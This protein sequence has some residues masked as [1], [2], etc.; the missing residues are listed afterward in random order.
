M[1]ELRPNHFHAGLDI[2]TEGRTGLPVYAAEFGFI[3][4]I[5]IQEG[6]YGNALYVYHPS[7]KQTT[8]YAHLKKFSPKI[9]QYVR[10]KQYEK[11]TFTIELFPQKTDFP[12]TRG[13]IIAYSGNTGG[14]GGPHLHFEIR[15]KDQHL[16]NPLN[17][18]FK[19]VKDDIPPNIYEVL[20]STRTK[21]SRVNNEFGKTP[22]KPRKI[23]T[24]SYVIDQPI[25]ANGAIAIALKT[26][27]K[28]NG[29]SNKNGTNYIN[30]YVDDTP[31]FKYNNNSFS[32]GKTRYINSHFDFELADK[33][34]GR[35]HKLFVDDGNALKL[36]PVL[37]NNGILSI[38]QNKKY[39][40]RIECIDAFGN[41]S[42]LRFTIQGN[43]SPS[44]TISHR[45]HLS[46][47]YT[48]SII[49]NTLKITTPKLPSIHLDNKEVLPAYHLSDAS[50]FLYDLKNTATPD[51]LSLKNNS[52]ALHFIQ[53]VK[54]K[55][56]THIY[57]STA[58]FHIPRG[59]FYDTTYFQYHTKND[60]FYIHHSTTA[61][62]RYVNIT[63]KLDTG[64]HK[65]KTH[66]Y[67][68]DSEGTVYFEGGNWGINGIHFRTRSLG[69]YFIQTD[70]IPPKIKYSH[71]SNGE[72]Y[73]KAYDLKSGLKTYNAYINDEWLLLH[74][75]YK[76]NLLWSERLDKTKALKG[77]LKVIAT[78]Q[79]GNEKTLEINL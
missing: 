68:M 54:P 78:D 52:Y 19:E 58:D 2:K 26:N 43:L 38:N 70:T 63:L 11:Q 37:I 8:V 57:S 9:A 69:R 20:L 4:R 55:E 42:T 15:N 18:Q 49:N 21:D 71:K 24:K 36:Y 66:V 74:Y 45:S 59:A 46:S 31:L 41:K 76:R 10:E 33:G 50:V 56:K 25:T 17:F 6:G 23:G 67:S 35:L 14:S 48:Q 60:T 47:N 40:I 62:Q 53:A 5:K 73:L 44:K 1:G 64:N 65:N 12:V 61:L 13:D 22:F 29:S 16:L 79:A 75:D 51:T 28:L 27:D 34:H 7:T 72:V 3:M 39:A 32:F 30:L 77:L